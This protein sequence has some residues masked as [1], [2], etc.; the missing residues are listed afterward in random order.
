MHAAKDQSRKTYIRFFEL[1]SEKRSG[2]CHYIR[3]V[4]AK[5]RQAGMTDRDIGIAAQMFFWGSLILSSL[6]KH[7]ISGTLYLTMYQC[8]RK[9]LQSLFLAAVPHDIQPRTSPRHSE[10]DRS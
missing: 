7:F 6:L 9:P 8:K 1:P 3:T 10:R 2:A 4:E 5:Q